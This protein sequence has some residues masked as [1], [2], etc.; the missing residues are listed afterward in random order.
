MIPG[1]TEEGGGFRVSGVEVVSNWCQHCDEVTAPVRQRK[2]TELVKDVLSVRDGG[3]EPVKVF[4]VYPL[5][6]ERDHPKEVTGVRTEFAECGGSERQFDGCR[7]A[8]LVVRS[9]HLRPVY[10]PLLGQPTVIPR[11]I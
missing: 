1:C 11:V 10:V 8:F 7:Q 5:R 2:N 9:K 4:L 6:E 3:E